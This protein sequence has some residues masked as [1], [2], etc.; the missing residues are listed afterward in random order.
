MKRLTILLLAISIIVIF[1]GCG[2]KE[3]NNIETNKNKVEQEK[4]NYVKVSKV[5]TKDFTQKL[6]LP[7]T[8][9]PK[10]TVI[11][12][13]KVGGT[14][15]RINGDIGS[16]VN[17]GSL[18]CKLSD[19]EYQL[20]YDNALI[21]LNKEKLTYEQ[22]TS[23]Y[24]R[25]KEL[26]DSG[27]IASVDFEKVEHQYKLG[28]ELINL[29]ENKFEL[30]KQNLAYTSITAPISGIISQKDVN[31]GE[32]VGV[33]KMIFTIVN[34]SEVFAETG[35]SENDISK[36][37]LGQN[38]SIKVDSTDST[39]KGRITHIGPVPNQTTKTYPVKILANN[40]KNILK[41]GMFSTVEIMLNSHKGVMGIQ[42]EALIKENDKSFVFVEKD[43]KAVK[44][45]V[46]IGFA[47]ES[48]VEVVSGID[49]DDNLI[50]VGKEN[51]KDGSK[52]EV[53]E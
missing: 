49:K 31:I 47:D 10:E 34:V 44:K 38:V 11:V 45:E 21:A 50:V 35:I 17:K 25:Y 53:K 18:L 43:S 46:E 7:A 8:L 14:V 12:T 6:S 20:Q 16:R 28:A 24:N 51:L 4:M 33:G 23:D 29:A 32:N 41:P 26:I 27:A 13:S 37:K 42:K 39:V 19:T 52:V 5:E 1:V 9:E 15:E 22:T 2:K 30:S 40:S 3:D 48:Y 36:V